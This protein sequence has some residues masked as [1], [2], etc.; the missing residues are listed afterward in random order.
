MNINDMLAFGLEEAK[1]ELN[2]H[3]F[4]INEVKYLNQPPGNPRV[5]RIKETTF[6]R[7]EILC[8]YHKDLIDP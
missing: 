6:R 2:K 1:I 4:Y 5:V 7:V 3:G 8:S